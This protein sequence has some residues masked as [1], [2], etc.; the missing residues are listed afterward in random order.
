[1]ERAH[2]DRTRVL[3]WALAVRDRGVPEHPARHG[4]DPDTRGAAPPVRPVGGGARVSDAPDFRDLVG[5]DLPAEEAQR[6]E[7]VHEMLVAPA[8]PP[9]APPHPQAAVGPT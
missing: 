5:E 3:E 2:R 7:R 4:E 1:V 6:L 8:P 9:E